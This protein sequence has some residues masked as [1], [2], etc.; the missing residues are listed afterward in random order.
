LKRDNTIIVCVWDD[1]DQVERFR[2]TFSGYR[3]KLIEGSRFK[4]ITEAYN[5]ALSEDA[6]FFLFMHQD[7]SGDFGRFFEWI[8]NIRDGVF[9]IVGR[10]LLNNVWGKDLEKP[11]EVLT[12]DECC[13]GFF[14]GHEFRFDTK[15]IWSCYSQDICFQAERKGIKRFVVPSNLTHSGDGKRIQSVYQQDWAYL[16]RKWDFPRWRT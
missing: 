16:N 15:L 11:V 13:I 12:I 3:L 2:R 7:V 5:S 1:F 4:T 10:T 14:R 9:G 8:G 6:E